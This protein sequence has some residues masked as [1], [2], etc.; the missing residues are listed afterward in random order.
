MPEIRPFEPDPGNTGVGN[1]QIADRI[2]S[3]AV[4]S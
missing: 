4:S 3:K 1:V 2:S